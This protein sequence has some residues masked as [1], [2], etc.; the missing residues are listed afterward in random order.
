MIVEDNQQVS[1]KLAGIVQEVQGRLRWPG[2]RRKET[3]TPTEVLIVEDAPPA[4]GRKRFLFFGRRRTSA[5]TKDTQAL[6]TS[7]TQMLIPAKNSFQKSHTGNNALAGASAGMMVSICLHPIDTVKVL[8]QAEAKSV[9]HLPAILGKFVGQRGLGGLYGGIWPN[10]A[11]SAPISAIYTT[12]YEGVK[13]RILPH[14]SKNNQWLAHVVAG[15]MASVATSFVY[16]PSECIKQ[17][18]QVTAHKSTWLAVKTIMKQDGPF[19]FY[20]GWTAVLCRN[21]PHSAFKFFAFEQMKAAVVARNEDRPMNTMQTLAV[22]GMSGSTAALFTTPF[23]VIKTRLQTQTALNSTV[24]Y[25]GVA[26][27]LT[28]I[29]ATE[30]LGGLYRGIVPRIVI[31]ISQG[32][33]F[34]ASYEFMKQMMDKRSLHASVVRSVEDRAQPLTPVPAR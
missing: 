13:E 14:L 28:R 25:R 9:R 21:I 27:A 10:L 15:G 18:M 16:T 32:A 7:T 26:D 30:G 5:T 6:S 22:G 19:G 3:K 12:A 1:I 34:F 33:I 8:I 4:K 24:Q 17:R 29:L 23:D 31:Y 20:R 11:S 2:S